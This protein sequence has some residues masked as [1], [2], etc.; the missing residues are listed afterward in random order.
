MRRREH[1]KLEGVAVALPLA[2]LRI[3]NRPDTFRSLDLMPSSQVPQV[4]WKGVA[5]L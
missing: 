2:L 4:V 1:Y 5:P 3:R